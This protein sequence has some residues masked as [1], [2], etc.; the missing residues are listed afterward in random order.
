[1]AGSWHIEYA[2]SVVRIDIPALPKAM[3]KRI[4]TAIEDRLMRDPVHFGRPLRYSLSGQRR[5]R[6]GDYRVV[7]AVDM[8][9]K[10]VIINA[11]KH[12]KDVYD[13]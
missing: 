6:V 11:I 13:A 12:R 5:L 1:M 4:K 3:Q 8:E 2:P 10:T 9:R 7:Y